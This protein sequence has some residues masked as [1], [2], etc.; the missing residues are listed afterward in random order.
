MSDVWESFKLA[1]ELL[2]EWSRGLFRFQRAYLSFFAGFHSLHQHYVLPPS[3]PLLKSEN[4]CDHQFGKWKKKIQ[5]KKKEWREKTEEIEQRRDDSDQRGVA[6]CTDRGRDS[7]MHAHTHTHARSHTLIRSQCHGQDGVY[8]HVNV[9]YGTAIRNTK[10]EATGVD[11]RV[12]Q[13]KQSV[14]LELA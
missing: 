14:H 11:E 8:S 10:G 4:R 6:C 5:I 3:L 13:G 9:C 1:R 7:Q 12:R 2:R